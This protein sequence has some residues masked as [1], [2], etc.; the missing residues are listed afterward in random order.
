MRGARIFAG[1]PSP[2]MTELDRDH[3]DVERGNFNPRDRAAPSFRS[4][5]AKRLLPSLAARLAGHLEP[6]RVRPNS[7]S[8]SAARA[9]CA[10]RAS[11]AMTRRNDG[12]SAPAFF[13]EVG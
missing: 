12:A 8:L 9:S 11:E 3:Q 4:V 7:S 10:S 6:R 13:V 2:E 5:S 1:D